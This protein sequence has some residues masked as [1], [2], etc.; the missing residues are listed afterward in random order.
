[1]NGLRKCVAGG[2][3]KWYSG[4]LASGGPEFKLQY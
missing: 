3:L 1:M 4:S 2:V